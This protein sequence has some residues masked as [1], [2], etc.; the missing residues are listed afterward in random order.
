[1]VVGDR[2]AVGDATEA[3]LAKLNSEINAIVQEPEIAKRFENAGLQITVRDRAT[4]AK[5]LQT[6]IAN[7]TTMVKAV[8]VK[9]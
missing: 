8:G 1:M 9:Q 4:T 5:L 7:W 2:A 6:D 3:V